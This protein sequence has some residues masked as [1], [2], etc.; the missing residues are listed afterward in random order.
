MEKKSLLPGIIL[1]SIGLLFLATNLNLI[2]IDWEDIWYE[3]WTLWPLAI[4][5]GGVLFWLGWLKNRNDYG[6][7]MPGT[8]MIIYGLLFWYC[9][10]FGWWRMGEDRLWSLFIIAPGLG[11][12]AMYALGKQ[13][14]GFLV[15]AIILTLLGVFFLTGPYSWRILWPVVL[16]LIGV[17]LLMKGKKKTDALKAEGTAPVDNAK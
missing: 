2:W 1:I 7:L 4:L 17:R 12:F 10:E 11:F 3:F 8:I 5:V 15:P 6:L 16:I 9:M 13:E 14:K